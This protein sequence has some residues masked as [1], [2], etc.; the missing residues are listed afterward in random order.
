MAVNESN[1]DK[2]DNFEDRL[3]R[4]DNNEFS[5]LENYTNYTK[6]N[7]IKLTHRIFL[8]FHINY[9]EVQGTITSK[10]YIYKTSLTEKEFKESG[11]SLKVLI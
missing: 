4:F 11:N 6:S 10:C 3:V 9:G 5:L 2:I 8:T 7:V 1:F